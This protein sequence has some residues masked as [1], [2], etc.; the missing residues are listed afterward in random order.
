LEIS[1]NRYISD[2]R[3]FT[4]YRSHHDHF[5]LP[6]TTEALILDFD[7][8]SA[9]LALT[10]GIRQK[11][12]RK[13]ILESLTEHFSTTD[14]SRRVT[15]QEIE[16]V[17]NPALHLQERL[18]CDVIVAKLEEHFH[19]AAEP[20]H[21][22]ERWQEHVAQLIASVDERYGCP[23]ASKFVKGLPAL[24]KGAAEREIPIALCTAGAYEYVNT[25]VHSI[26]LNVHLDLAASVYTNRH[27][28]IRNKPFADPY[29]RTCDNLRVDPTKVVI[30]EDSASGALAALRSGGLVMFQPS[31]KRLHTI[32]SLVDQVKREHSE[33]FHERC[34]SVALFAANRGWTQARFAQGSSSSHR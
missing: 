13:V 27:P 6:V 31:G 24:L 17:H 8:T 3:L 10:E 30:A 4:L 34:G 23:G 20:N 12:F 14:P 9:P 28:D 21:L 7:G 22:W 15:R 25:F 5:Y 33:W 32:Q 16:R 2:G 19:F 1:R 29:L 11:A 26:G 18:M